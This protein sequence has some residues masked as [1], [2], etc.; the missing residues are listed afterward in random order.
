MWVSKAQVEEVV[1]PGIPAF[2]D[3]ASGVTDAPHP[4]GA[5]AGN[6]LFASQ[7]SDAT[8]ARRQPTDNNAA[9]LSVLKAISLKLS[10]IEQSL[11]EF[12]PQMAPPNPPPIP[13]PGIV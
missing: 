7:N 4:E 12:K 6:P 11:S 13:P 3:W 5:D 2:A 10:N 1:Q 8:Q 9:V